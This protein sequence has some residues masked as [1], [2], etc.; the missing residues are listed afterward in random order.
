MIITS[1]FVACAKVDNVEDRGN[2][3]IR[4]RKEEFFKESITFNI[5]LFFNKKTPTV[6]D[7]L[8]LL[9]TFAA[10]IKITKY[11]DYSLHIIA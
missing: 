1:H 4:N 6:L 2:V 5:V 7:S 10:N 9:S 3:D 8:I 11:A